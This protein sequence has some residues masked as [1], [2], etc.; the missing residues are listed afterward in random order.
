M[1]VFREGEFSVNQVPIKMVNVLID[2]GPLQSS[3]ISKS[4]VDS[5]RTHW[6]SAIKKSA[7]V[8]RL[9]DQTN[10]KNSSEIVTGT[11]GVIDDEGR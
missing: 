9:A 4:L 5:H 10:K 7:F 8:V 2:T 6:N 1:G 11:I 3:Y